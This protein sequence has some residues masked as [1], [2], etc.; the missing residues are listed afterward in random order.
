MATLNNP[1]AINTIWGSLF[2]SSEQL[3]ASKSPAIQASIIVAFV[4]TWHNSTIYRESTVPSPCNPSRILVQSMN[5]L[6]IHAIP[7]EH[8]AEGYKELERGSSNAQNPQQSCNPDYVPKQGRSTHTFRP[9]PQASTTQAIPSTPNPFA[10][11]QSL[12]NSQSRQNIW[13]RDNRN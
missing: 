2:K 13:L 7:S 4:I 5:P 12:S 9:E 6:A 11:L 8:L 3:R 10:I 1:K